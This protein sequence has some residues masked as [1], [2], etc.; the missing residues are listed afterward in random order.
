MLGFTALNI[1]KVGSA[2]T[3]I[4]YT[5]RRKNE[6]L[7]L[8]NNFRSQILVAKYFVTMGEN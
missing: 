7:N 6:Q 2:I 1:A 5:I 3:I 4:V 8:S